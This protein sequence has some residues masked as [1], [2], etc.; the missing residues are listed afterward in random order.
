MA[1]VAAGLLAMSAVG[2]GIAAAPDSTADPVECKGGTGKV[3][4]SGTSATGMGGFGD[5]N[6]DGCPG[7][8][9]G[10]AEDI[11]FE[12]KGGKCVYTAPVVAESENDDGTKTKSKTG[13]VV[14]FTVALGE[15]TGKATATDADETM[16]IE[17]TVSEV[18]K[19]KECK[20]LPDGSYKVS[21]IKYTTKE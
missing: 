10:E 1:Y 19:M 13:T 9:E 7:T 14:T 6:E 12:T 11:T 4:I 16:N 15:T 21:K 3:T 2:Y 18:P 8:T 20:A 5:D 17:G